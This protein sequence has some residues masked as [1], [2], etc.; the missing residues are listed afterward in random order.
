MTCSWRLVA[1]AAVATVS[2]CGDAATGGSGGGEGTGGGSVE[3]VVVTFA[4]AGPLVL[5]P[6]QA[7]SVTVTTQPPGAHDVS[8]LLLGD[9]LDAS[10]DDDATAADA[11]GAATVTLQAP[12]KTA[13]FRVR[14]TIGAGPAAELVVR[15][16]ELGTGVVRVL[17]S[18][19]GTRTTET[20]SAAIVPRCPELSSTTPFPDDDVAFVTVPAGEEL[21]LENVPVGPRLVVVARS[22]HKVWGCAEVVLE[23]AEVTEDVTVSVLDRPV[24]L[25]AA[26]LTVELGWAGPS[27]DVRTILDRAAL[28]IADASFPADGEPSTILLDALG[29]HLPPDSTDAFEALRAGGLDATLGA[30]LAAREVSPR[31]A[32][33]AFLAGEPQSGATI[34]RLWAAAGGAE[35]ALFAIDRF[36]GVDATQA[37]V[38][39]DHLMSFGA[40]PG[41]KIVIGGV[42]YFLP[43]RWATARAEVAAAGDAPGTLARDVL[44]AAVG[45]DAVAEVIGPLGDCDLACAAEACRLGL[46]DLWGRGRDASAEAGE[47]GSLSMAASGQ[48]EVD[49]EAALVGFDGTWVGVM[50]VFGAEAAVEGFAAA[51]ATSDGGAPDDDGS[52]AP[53]EA[54]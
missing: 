5:A 23:R 51:E 32:V 19:A 18:Y 17:P 31:A 48:G 39:A 27:G 44:A 3:G 54:E 14:A 1:L 4:D 52:D 2:A 10:L 24:Q 34:G 6:G 15:V 50:S 35:H 46:G 38:P 53:G 9:S 47:L 25:G 11:T 12:S 30:D 33:L 8:F 37:G 29:A 40:N 43:S 7:A 41:D 28:R 16:S 45:C 22:A 20:W 36:L 21:L 42:V 26:D 49:D 13:T